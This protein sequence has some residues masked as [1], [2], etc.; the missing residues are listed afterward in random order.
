MARALV[1]SSLCPQPQPQPGPVPARRPSAR[2]IVVWSDPIA[3]S[4]HSDAYTPT[5]NEEPCTAGMSR[6][7]T[8][9]PLV[10]MLSALAPVVPLSSSGRER[11]KAR[12][13]QQGR[14]SQHSDGTPASLFVHAQ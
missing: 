7:P 12:V 1:S 4:G 9:K 11:A 2:L 10:T 14:A 8:R 5:P 6:P 3:V 13:S